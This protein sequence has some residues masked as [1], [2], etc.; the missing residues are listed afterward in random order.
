MTSGVT[1]GLSQGGELS[2]GRPI[3]LATPLVL[4]LSEWRSMDH[5]WAFF[6]IL[7]TLQQH[8]FLCWTN[9]SRRKA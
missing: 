3:S 1:R 2:W 8:S 7:S 5:N 4:S 9:K 6:I